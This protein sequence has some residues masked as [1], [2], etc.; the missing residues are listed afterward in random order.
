[1]SEP[2]QVHVIDVSPRD[3]LQNEPVQ[4]TTSDKLALI[5]GLIAGGVTAIEAASFVS[6]SKVPAMAD[7]DALM[8]E[9]P[10]VEGVR[11]IGLV[12]N[13][14]GLDRAFEAEVDEVNIVVSASDTF[15][16]RN[17]GVDT[18][19]GVSLAIALAE[20]CRQASVD[21]SITIA[22]AFGCPFEGE[23]PVER[24]VDV[25]RMLSETQPVRLN[26]GDTI[27][28]AVPSDVVERFNAINP[29]LG[30]STARGAH[31]HNTRNTGYANAYAALTVGVSHFD[32]SVGGIGGCPFAPNAT[33]NVA[34]E[35]LGYM[36]ERMGLDTGLNLGTLMG[37]SRW[38]EGPL[39]KSLPA[40]L[41]RAGLFPNESPDSG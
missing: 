3:G 28:V 1:M 23:L 29:Y 17:Q 11:Y 41:G 35:D 33:G 19:A 13:E 9:V 32:A 15:S 21:A 40:L 4:V 26:L 6:P 31:F 37:T 36:F 22:T 10:R 25:V 2:S 39:G 34:T 38:L 5:E 18:L 7:S 20:R 12:M 27:G 16:L 14:R 24:L 8:R 30:T